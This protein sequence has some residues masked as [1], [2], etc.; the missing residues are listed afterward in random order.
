MNKDEIGKTC[1]TH[2]RSEIYIRFV[3]RSLKESSHVGDI[4]LDVN[5]F[6]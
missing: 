3:L 4:G 2:R 1:N 5:M 6:K